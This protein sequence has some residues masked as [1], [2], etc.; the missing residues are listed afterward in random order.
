MNK[1][2]FLDR[3]GVVIVEKD[4]LRDVSQVELETGAAEAIRQLKQHGYLVIVVSNQSG[5]ARGYF[6]EEDVRAVNARI[7]ALLAAEGTAVDDWFFCPHHPQGKI[8]AYTRQCDC[9]KPG[10]GMLLQ[11]AQKHHIDLSA[12]FMI[13]DKLS[14]VATG[15]AAGCAAAVLVRTGHGG[16]AELPTEDV[17]TAADIRAA[18]ALLLAAPFRKKCRGTPNTNHPNAGS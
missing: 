4:Y 6:S 11:A 10:T 12:S 17:P 3:D 5:V 15:R 14:D 18:V 13:G 9:R 7:D 1:A 8:P 2:C 16:T